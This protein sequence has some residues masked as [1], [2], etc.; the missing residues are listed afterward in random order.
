M[1][2]NTSILKIVTMFFMTVGSFSSCDRAASVSN[3]RK[4]VG[5]IVGFYCSSY[6]EG[7]PV[8]PPQY[9]IVTENLVDTLLAFNLQYELPLDVNDTGNHRFDYKVYFTY[10]MANQQEIES[11][12]RICNTFF[13][14]PYNRAKPIMINSFEKIK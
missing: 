12:A 11:N 13:Y 9:Y 7:T 3:E 2:K 4:A 8:M 10:R 14:D 6:Y 1:K 5:Y